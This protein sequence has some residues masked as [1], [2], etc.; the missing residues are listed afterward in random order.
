M[1]SKNCNIVIG[2]QHTCVKVETGN[3][4]EI[5]EKKMVEE[6]PV[7]WNRRVKLFS[8]SPNRVQEHPFQIQL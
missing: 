8:H 7:H 3:N 4:D 1:R 6:K 5:C 2:N